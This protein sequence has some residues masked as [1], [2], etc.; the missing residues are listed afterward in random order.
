MMNSK[1]VNQ[2]YNI[3]DLA[4]DLQYYKTKLARVKSHKIVLATKL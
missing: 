2:L 1:D 3:S 4:V